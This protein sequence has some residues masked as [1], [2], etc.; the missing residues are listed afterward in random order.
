M[1]AGTKAEIHENCYNCNQ[2]SRMISQKNV[3]KDLKKSRKQ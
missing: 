2:I 3:K 1:G